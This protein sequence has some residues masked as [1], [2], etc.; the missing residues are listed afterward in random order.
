MRSGLKGIADQHSKIS[1]SFLIV[2][3]ASHAAR[4]GPT[5]LGENEEEWL[6]IVSTLLKSTQNNNLEINFGHAL[7]H[8]PH[9]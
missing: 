7:G 6:K 4:A 3:G 9:C 2:N 5:P 1:P 8:D